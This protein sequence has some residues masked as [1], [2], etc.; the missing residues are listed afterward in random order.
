MYPYYGFTFYFCTL[1]YWLPELEYVYILFIDHSYFFM[2]YSTLYYMYH[3]GSGEEYQSI[4]SQLSM[5][6]KARRGRHTLPRKRKARK[7]NRMRGKTTAEGECVLEKSTDP[8]KAA[9]IDVRR[10]DCSRG[11]AVWDRALWARWADK[12]ARLHTLLGAEALV[13]TAC[14]HW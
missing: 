12:M 3:I 8:P 6:V 7:S 5:N 9:L 10:W 11:T 13:K 4:S 1:C 14:L 2:K